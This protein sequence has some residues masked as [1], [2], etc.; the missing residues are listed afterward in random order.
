MLVV[1]LCDA[2]VD[3]LDDDGDGD[4]SEMRMWYPLIALTSYGAAD[5]GGRRASSDEDEVRAERPTCPMFRT[6]MTS[7]SAAAP[8]LLSTGPSSSATPVLS[9]TQP[10]TRR[11]CNAIRTALQSAYAHAEDTPDPA[12]AHAAVLVPFCNV[13]GKPGVLLEVRGK[14]RTHSGEV[15]YVARCMA[16]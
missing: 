15:R 6:L 14:L 5:D 16:S 2:E 12:E 10:L 13:D 8:A 9:L 3:V 11:S 7:A 1:G 4:A